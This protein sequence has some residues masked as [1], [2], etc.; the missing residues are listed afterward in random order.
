MLHQ[1]NLKIYPIQLIN[2]V[3][4]NKLFVLIVIKSLQQELIIKLEEVQ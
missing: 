2:V 1:L 3:I 4:Q